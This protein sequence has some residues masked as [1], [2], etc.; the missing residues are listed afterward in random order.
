MHMNDV[1]PATLP[2]EEEEEEYKEDKKQEATILGII[3]ML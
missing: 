2:E 1:N 3:V